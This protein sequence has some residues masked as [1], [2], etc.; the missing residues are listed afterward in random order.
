MP[1]RADGSLSDP[2][3]IGV[4]ARP[5]GMGKAYVAVA[6]DGDAI[7]MNPAGIARATSPKLTSMYSSL[8]N[9]V[10]YTVVGG[11]YPYGAKSAIG[12]GFVNARVGDIP[13]TD[14]NGSST[15]TGSWGNSVMFLSYGTY[16]SELPLGLKLDRDVLL[17]ASLK[18]FSVGGDGTGVKDGSGTGY[19]VDLG[20]LYPVNDYIML[21]A[22][23]QNALPASMGGKITNKTTGQTDSIL[24]TLKVGTRVTLMGNEGSA[25]L[26]QTN[27]RLYG[28]FDYDINQGGQPGVLHAGLEFWP[29]ANLAL[30][31]GLDDKDMTAGIGVRFSG[32]EFNYAYH[33]YNGISNDTTHYFSIGYIGEP[34]K[35]EINITLDEPKDKS[36]VYDD[37]V[38]VK[39]RVDVKEGDEEAPKGPI[40]LR[41]NGANIAVNA[42][43]TF[44]ADLPVENYGK[45]LIVAE[46]TDNAGTT[47]KL[48]ARLVHLQ[49]FADV[50][51]GYWAKSPIENT[52]T[53]ALVNG[54]PD[55]TFRPE[56]AL[57]RAELA[58]LLVRA[59]GI[60]LPDGR[61]QQK[62]KDVKPDFWA[63]KYIQVAQREGLVKGYPDKSFRPNNKINKVE[64][65]AVMVRFDQLRLASVDSKPYWD[66][67]TNHWGA[68]YIQAAKEAGMLKFIERN[69]LRPKEV[70]ARAESVEMLGKTSLAGAKI[71]DLYTWEKGFKP[72]LETRPN[73]KAS[74]GGEEYA[75]LLR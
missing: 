10:N 4:G 51:D 11:V 29:T 58:T 46:A 20:A 1:A 3:S 71:K 49:S 27:R 13:L 28:N 17:G 59:K 33:P 66:I 41:L 16:L 19:N 54:Y 56:N 24:R 38:K 45:K 63:A 67:P 2:M 26:P 30:R 47:G 32:V 65:I 5:L 70:L 75:A 8:M 74:L 12:A 42:D 53:V 52:A 6:E 9:D 73:I 21:G 57:T 14:V 40:G 43:G 62:F 61:A 36:I 60:K 50:P 72:E 37:H 35:R 15:G 68:K 22:N 7:F 48:E 25:L 55:R 44:T 34:R 69:K 18:Y 39:G 31:G 23:L 64:G